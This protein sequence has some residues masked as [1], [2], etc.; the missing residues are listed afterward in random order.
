MQLT[1]LILLSL[2][3]YS[4]QKSTPEDSHYVAAVVEYEF[5]WDVQRNVHNYIELIKD[6]SAQNADVVV[7]PELSLNPGEEYYIPIPIKSLLKEHPIPAVRPD[8]YHEILVAIST[9]ARENDIY[10]VVNIQEILN[11]PA[12]EEECPEMKTYIFNANVVFDRQGAV[13]DRYRK[14]NLFG[15]YTRTPA[16]K[17]ELGVFSTDFGVTFGHFICFDLKFQVPGIQTPQ[18][19]N[20]TDIIFPAMWVSELPYLTAVQIQEGY[21]IA[22]NVNLIAAGANNITEGGAGSGIYSG[23]AGALISIMPGVPTTRLLVA[24]VP[25]VPGQVTEPYSGPIPSDPSE[26]DNLLINGDPSMAGHN[27]RLL[28]PGYQEFV[29]TSD[30][31]ICSFKINLTQSDSVLYKYR[32]GALNGV[33]TYA[34][35]A[36]GGVKI[37]GVFACTGDTIDTCSKRFSKYTPNSLAT[38]DELSIDAFVTTPKRNPELQADNIVY[39]PVSLQPTILPLQ[40]KDYSLNITSLVGVLDLYSYKL[41]NHNAE[42][43]S[44]GIFGRVFERD[45]ETPTHPWVDFGL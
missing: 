6:A 12:P 5:S 27:S 37:C 1:I 23:R 29:L 7:F 41:L 8:L 16:L 45:G 40:P 11:C 28:V 26:L 35:K 43:Y 20:V 14:M 24:R 2:T 22:M 31:A 10:V 39:F 18:K 17:P 4:M 15:E 36:S 38:F 34:G 3:Q 25:K 32:A 21:A 13:I 19:L 30:D 42:L 33:R 9:A 44:F